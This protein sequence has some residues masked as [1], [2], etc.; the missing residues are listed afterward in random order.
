MS[1]KQIAGYSSDKSTTRVDINSTLPT[2][3]EKQ[4]SK[5]EEKQKRAAGITRFTDQSI[6]SSKLEPNLSSKSSDSRRF[7]VPQVAGDWQ[8][9]ILSVKRESGGQKNVKLVEA[10]IEQDEVQQSLE[11]SSVDS[12]EESL[13]CVLQRIDHKQQ[14]HLNLLYTNA[15]KKN[16]GIEI[17]SDTSQ[18]DDNC[19]LEGSVYRGSLLPFSRHFSVSASNPRH[20]SAVEDSMPQSSSVGE[21]RQA[22]LKKKR[23]KLRSSTMPPVH[24]SSSVKD[25]TKEL[26]PKCLCS[27]YHYPGCASETKAER[28]I[29]RMA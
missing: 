23:V 12:R 13:N 24:D 2:T 19:E 9:S 6:P 29:R 22:K 26:C 27:G 8:K 15:N 21:L 17:L 5:S 7:S 18:S 16:S 11:D 1:D 28:K 3:K 4:G 20:Y 10:D 25:E 14:E